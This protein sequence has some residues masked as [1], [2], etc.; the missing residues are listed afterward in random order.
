MAAGRRVLAAALLLAV[1][2]LLQHAAARKPTTRS[3]DVLAGKIREI[4]KL[5]NPSK[6]DRVCLDS[7]FLSLSSCAELSNWIYPR[8][9]TSPWPGM[10]LPFASACC[11]FTSSSSS[12]PSF[13][14]SS[15]SFRSPSPVSSLRQ[16]L[17]QL[18]RLIHPP[19]CAIPSK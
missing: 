11:Y 10:L 15:S 19:F 8:G 16:H 2:L 13:P 12:S 9:K 1:P 14:S 3:Q 6:L 18:C 5:N 17:L 7:R 4:Y